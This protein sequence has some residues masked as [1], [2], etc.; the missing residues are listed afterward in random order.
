MIRKLLVF[1][2]LCATPLFCTEPKRNPEILEMAKSW[3]RSLA[4]PQVDSPEAFAWFYPVAHPRFNC[5]LH[6]DYTEKVGEHMDALIAQAPAMTPIA[7]WT[8]PENTHPQVI[9]ALKTR[10]FASIGCYP[11][12][13][14]E[15]KPTDLPQFE[16]READLNVFHT[17]LGV[18]LNYNEE[19]QQASLNLL[20][21]KRAE[22]YLIY[23]EGKP[24][25]TGTLFIHKDLGMVAHI[26]T[27]PEYQKRGIGR[28]IMQY[29]MH[30]ASE[31]GLKKLVLY[32]SHV[33][34]K[35][36]LNLGFQKVG[37]AEIYIRDPA[38]L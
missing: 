27:L 36:Y 14:W 17:I 2:V 9:E 29:M 16:V 3:L 13:I 26:A 18:C 28:A 24:V 23:L 6:F 11:A 32:S 38:S 31:R 4:D 21:D 1:A 5:I 35:L 15:V 12:M 30:Q 33:A 22:H 34:Q 20:K 25:G 19:A 8:D 37:D 7:F 10:N